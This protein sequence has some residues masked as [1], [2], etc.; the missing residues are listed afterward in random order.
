MGAHLN[1]KMKQAVSKLY[2]GG[3]RY[4]SFRMPFGIK[5]GGDWRLGGSRWPSTELG[6]LQLLMTLILKWSSCDFESN[7][8]FAMSF[9]FIGSVSLCCVHSSRFDF[10]FNLFVY[11]IFYCCCCCWRCC[12]YR[13]LLER[14]SVRSVVESFKVKVKV[15][16]PYVANYL[17]PSR[18][19][20]LPAYNALSVPLP[21]C[22]P[23][24]CCLCDLFKPK[25]VLSNYLCCECYIVVFADVIIKYICIYI[26][27][28]ERGGFVYDFS[29]EMP[30][31][32]ILPSPI[33]GQEI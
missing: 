8:K 19:I 25:L 22:L 12:F 17:S 23:P 13:R 6:Q 28:G 26:G 29:N 11:T 9:D 1:C 33:C 14:V 10:D 31:S 30:V 16:L 27:T 15:F 18:S 3:L 4:N 5:S 21:A 7:Y 32:I 2:I 24:F 20:A